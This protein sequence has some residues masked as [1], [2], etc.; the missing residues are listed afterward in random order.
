MVGYMAFIGTPVLDLVT[1]NL[2]RI[3]GVSL[4]ANAS[5]T[6]GLAGA[7]G[8]PLPDILLPPDFLPPSFQGRPVALADGIRVSIEPVSAGPFTNLP[9][10]IVKAGTTPE[11]FTIGITNTKVDET[12]QTL[13]IYV[14]S[15]SS[16]RS[17]TVN[18]IGPT[19]DIQGPLIVGDERIG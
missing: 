2:V 19:G 16:A 4:A 6:I 12:T 5:G 8:S 18:I 15:V 7:I 17:P 1:P 11:D 14:E 3:T 13:E 10:S 9:P